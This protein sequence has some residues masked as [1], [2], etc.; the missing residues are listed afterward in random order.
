MVDLICTYYSTYHYY[1][2]DHLIFVCIFK[3]I[4]FRL[5]INFKKVRIVSIINPSIWCFPHLSRDPISYSQTKILKKYSKIL[6]LALIFLRSKEVADDV[7]KKSSFATIKPGSA[8]AIACDDISELLL[9]DLTAIGEAGLG[10]APSARSEL[11]LLYALAVLRNSLSDM[12]DVI[13]VMLKFQITLSPSAAA[14]VQ[15]FDP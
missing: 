6:A 11:S 14:F 1:H 8:L 10:R 2:D 5:Q 9:A 13:S 3:F 12:L 7:S 15:F 4:V